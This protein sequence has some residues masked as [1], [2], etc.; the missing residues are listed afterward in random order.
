MPLSNVKRKPWTIRMLE[1]IGVS[2]W[3]GGS[4]KKNK[5][6]KNKKTYKNK[7]SYKNKSK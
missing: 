7:K 2:H 4:K 6:N 5:T 3:W 1:K